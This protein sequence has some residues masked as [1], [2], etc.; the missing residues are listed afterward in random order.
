[1]MKNRKLMVIQSFSDK[2]LRSFQ[3]KISSKEWGNQWGLESGTERGVPVSVSEDV[4]TKQDYTKA[5]T[6]LLSSTPE[7]IP[8]VLIWMPLSSFL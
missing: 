5:E 4:A 3:G 8:A 6:W 7:K 2:G 1:M